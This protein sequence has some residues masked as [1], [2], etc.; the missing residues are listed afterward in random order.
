MVRKRDSHA[1]HWLVGGLV[2]SQVGMR[3]DWIGAGGYK[4][5]HAY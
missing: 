2:A 1:G 5:Y 4:W 3:F